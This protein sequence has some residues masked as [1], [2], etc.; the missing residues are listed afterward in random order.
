MG[1]TLRAYYIGH[2]GK[3]VPGKAM[4]VVIRAGLIRGSRV[5]TGIA[6]ASVF[7][8]TLTMMSVGAFWAAAVLA[9]WFRQHTFLCLVAVGLM[10]A[11]G[12]PILPPVF[13][14]LVK[15]VRVGKNDPEIAKRLDRLG[16]GILLLGFL[17]MSVSWLL[18]AVSLWAVLQA[19]NV[20]E[21]ALVSGMP[22]YLASVALS[23]VAGFLSLIPGGRRCSRTC[24]HRVDCPPIW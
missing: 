20:P 23:M 6:A 24:S 2:L 11:A 17:L 21:A 14:R 13:R 19:M 5:N 3:Y 7:Y 4:V 10:V 12:L 15:F 18:L 9:V 1:E 22:L 16:F 8:E